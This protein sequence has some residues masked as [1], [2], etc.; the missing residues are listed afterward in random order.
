MFKNM[1]RDG[2]GIQG[3]AFLFT[4]QMTTQSSCK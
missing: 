4:E 2:S 1:I 3:N